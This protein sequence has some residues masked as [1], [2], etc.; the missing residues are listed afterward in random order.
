[1]H[2]LSHFAPQLALPKRFDTTL[3]DTAL[4]EAA[5]LVA[6]YWTRMLDHLLASNWGGTRAVAA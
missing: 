4:G 2:S 3:A 1:M 6:A 5:P